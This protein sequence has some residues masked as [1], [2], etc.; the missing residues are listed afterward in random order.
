MQHLPSQPPLSVHYCYAPVDSAFLKALDNHLSFLKHNGW[1]QTWDD[2]QILAGQ[3]KER[4]QESYLHTSHLQ[5]LLI[6]A[7][8]LASDS[9]MHK[10]QVAMQRHQKG[11]AVVIPIIVRPVEWEPTPLRA[12]QALPRDGRPVALWG[13][14]DQAWTQIA[15]EVKV[16][17]GA[18]RRPVVVDSSPQLQTIAA[19]LI[20]F[21]EVSGLP[22][23][24]VE[25]TLEAT[26]L[27][28]TIRESSAVVLIASPEM[29]FARSLK[30]TQN[31]A[32]TYQCPVLGIWV[33]DA[34]QGENHDVAPP[35]EW[36]EYI[37]IDQEPGRQEEAFQEVLHRLKQLRYH[38]AL[39]VVTSSPHALVPLIEPRNPYKGLR[40]FT[41]N[42][43]RDFFGRAALIDELAHSVET[44]LTLTKKAVQQARLLAVVG[45][46]GLGKSSVVMA[47]LLPCL[48]TGEILDSETW[49]YL[50]PLVA[51]EHPLEELALTLFEHF[52]EK[53]QQML[54]DDLQDDSARGLHFYAT[55]LAR[56]TKSAN[57]YVVL[58]VDQFEELFAL[59]T[60]EEER[61][62]FIDL[63]VT[64]CTQPGGPLIVILTLRADFYDRPMQYPALYAL[65]EQHQVAMLPMTQNDLRA[66]ITQPAML[67]DVQLT[68]EGSLVGDLLFDVQGQIGA[69]PLLQF[70]LDQLFRQR[71][72]HL[73]ALQAY[74][75][76]GGVKGALSRHAEQ[77]Y[78]D[79]LSPE[80]RTN[81]RT[82]FLR[83][84]D[85]G[86]AEQDTTR[87]R[88][89]LSEF[90]FANVPQ[91]QC[92]QETIEVFIQARLL[93]TKKSGD[94]TTI[95]VSHEAV[96][97]EW[98]RLAGWLHEARDD[99]RFQQAFSEDVMEW[100]QQQQPK[101]RLYRGVQLKEAQAWANRN[102]LSE[103]EAIFLQKS[104]V[105]QTVSRVRLF[106]SILLGAFLIGLASWLIY[107]LPPSPTL[108]TTLQ[109]NAKETGT[110]RYCLDNAP[111]GSTITFA[112]GLKGIIKLTGGELAVGG[113]KR[114]TLRGPGAN[115]L[116]ISGV[117]VNANIHVPK[118]ATL[119]IYNLSFKNTQTRV[120]A[121]L[122]N[123]GTL[124]LTNSVISNNK[125][126]GQTVSYGGGIFNLGTLTLTDS[127][128]SNNSTSTDV[129][130]ASGGGIYNEGKLTVVH[131]IISN[132]SVSSSSNDGYGGGIENFK[133]GT[134]VVTNS[135]FSGNS[136]HGQQKGQGGGIYNEG[137][138][139]VTGSTFSNNSA[140]GSDQGASGGGIE[141][142]GILRL[143]N[144]IL[145]DNLANGKQQVDGG[146]IGNAGQLTVVNSTFSNN[147]VSSSDQDG[148]GG[149]IENVSRSI[150]TVTNSRFSGNS[151]NGKQVG[152][153][154]GI[155]NGAT[156]TVT[157]STFSNNS[158]S[159]SD[160]DGNGGGIENGG[161]L[162][163][164]N[165]IL[166]DNLASGKQFGDGG[167]IGN[168]GQLAAMHNTFTNNSARGTNQIG[169]GGG[170]LN[171]GTLSLASSTFSGNSALGKQQGNGGG[172]GNG[173]N[174]TV[175]NCT[176][177]KNTASS[178][179]GLPGFGGGI[180]NFYN[181][182]VDAS[183]FS[184]NSAMG[185]QSSQGGGIDNVK[186][187]ILTN[188]IIVA[189]NAP[190][191]PDIY[192]TLT[193]G[194]YNL[195][196]SV[197]KV[198]G[199]SSTDKQVT[200][201]DLKLDSTLSNNGGPTQTLKL[202][203]GSRAIDII[204]LQA[205]HFTITDAVS[206]QKMVITTD[207]RGDLRPDGSEQFC[208]VGAYESAY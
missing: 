8:F 149:G 41:S 180:D 205:C 138:L 19:H 32:A 84:I 169:V 156:L 200:L 73:L 14:R 49:V 187:L 61:Q 26:K 20:S 95:E 101:D 38:S 45:P 177:W 123:E 59:T 162:R 181:L 174:L 35:K 184:D 4:E 111:S 87:R 171:Q 68:F 172:I 92:M 193:S 75:D 72:G 137:T 144:S 129:Y 128:V 105:Q 1:I 183:T 166:S 104:I 44:M 100:E 37:S 115:Q 31:L 13:R 132:N 188:S 69:L 203:P 25:H 186:T 165:S 15:A 198:S 22:T 64:A 70:T 54:C 126:I 117:N 63:L 196:T 47:G 58:V 134:L 36:S 124:T 11:E 94:R 154:G 46:S 97:R 120:N 33:D 116:T 202:L 201:K 51:G 118:G 161:I 122:F 136:A 103:Q 71:A 2:Y 5:L 135:R 28:E 125:T 195:L 74:H 99:I 139:T 141:N 29:G 81:A 83:L 43:T 150:L 176:F 145:S 85:P 155:D 17:V 96:I 50:D 24:A 168:A 175:V 86:F 3:D 66:V 142:G 119:N 67:P 173:G 148:I 6:S 108:V 157:D 57:T 76:I 42:D 207:Q 10:M 191:G 110:L 53:S 7:D 130:A 80:H 98:K 21:L 189:N 89:P 194:G 147:S 27:H 62:Q 30:K 90:R 109:D 39:P 182:V 48:R 163:L 206:G 170:I 185:N 12:L 190:V 102:K 179:N 9:C 65:I 153:G 208:D 113:G 79:L 56:R 192:G 121:F 78:E 34:D 159:S 152:Q 146:G 151:A 40:A 55:A 140:S 158:A 167:G 106:A 60:N 199:L 91:T 164:T 204:P 133:A 143:T 107:I 93:T 197:A 18:L 16:V 178:S 88:A 112:N 114:L 77:T 82:L 127:T 160:Q 52:P 23:S 131:S